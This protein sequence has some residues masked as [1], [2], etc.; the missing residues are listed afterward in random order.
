MFM[1][2]LATMHCKNYAVRTVKAAQLCSLM[3]LVSITE[4]TGKRHCAA[5]V[6]TG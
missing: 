1:Q 4:I 2:Q 5:T 6:L 3:V